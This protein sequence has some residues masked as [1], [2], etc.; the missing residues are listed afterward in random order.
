MK[1]INAQHFKEIFIGD[2]H[3]KDTCTLKIIILKFSDDT[4]FDIPVNL[5]WT[6]LFQIRARGVLNLCFFLFRLFFNGLI[7]SCLLKVQRKLR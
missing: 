7:N 6:L 4:I 1:I 5:T 2:L 3:L